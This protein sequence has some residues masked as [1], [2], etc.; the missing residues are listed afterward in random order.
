MERLQGFPLAAIVLLWLVLPLTANAWLKEANDM[1]PAR[2]VSLAAI[3]L[4]SVVLPLTI[5]PWLTR[6][7]QRR[8]YLRRVLVGQSLAAV[9]GLWVIAAPIHPEFGLVVTVIACLACLPVRRR[10]PRPTLPSQA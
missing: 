6:A 8:N 1:D 4:F 2:G 9:G 10:Q 7:S 5:N 3:V